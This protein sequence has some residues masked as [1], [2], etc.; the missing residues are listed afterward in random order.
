MH[1]K[2]APVEVT[3][4]GYIVDRQQPGDVYA[5]YRGYYKEYRSRSIF[6]PL[7]CSNLSTYFTDTIDRSPSVAT[8][9][10]RRPRWLSEVS[11]QAPAVIIPSH[12]S[13]AAAER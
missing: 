12:R 8:S 4:L 11:S 9:E 7:C 13:I 10:Q 1:G 6:W 2:P 3:Q 5:S